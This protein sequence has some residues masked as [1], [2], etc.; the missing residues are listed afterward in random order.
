MLVACFQLWAVD[1]NCGLCVLGAH[2]QPGSLKNRFWVALTFLRS[3]TRMQ[4]CTNTAGLP[5][6]SIPGI[7]RCAPEEYVP[8]ASHQH[9][10]SVP[11]GLTSFSWFPWSRWDISASLATVLLFLRRNWQQDTRPDLMWVCMHYDGM[12][13]KLVH[14]SRAPGNPVQRNLH[15]LCQCGAN[16]RLEWITCHSDLAPHRTLQAV[17]SSTH[18]FPIIWYVSA[19]S[20]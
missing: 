5:P 11:V 9:Q 18:F 16:T 7:W 1:K 8:R 17:C 4:L 3:P 20:S 6:R 10:R 19:L 15:R 12:S 13:P 2:T 14:L